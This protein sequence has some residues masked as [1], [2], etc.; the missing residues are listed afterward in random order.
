MGP[1]LRMP[2]L[3]PEYKTTV[4]FQMYFQEKNIVLY[5]G[6]Y[7]IYIY[8]Y[9]YRYI[10]TY[11]YTTTILSVFSL[12][13]CRSSRP[14]CPV[15][16]M[17]LKTGPAAS[18]TFTGAEITVSVLQSRQQRTRIQHP[19]NVLH[20]FNAA[21]EASPDA[22]TRVSSHYRKSGPFLSHDVIWCV[23][24]KRSSVF[25]SVKNLG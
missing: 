8:I 25:R 15:S 22:F 14:S 21:P 5:S 4:F 6:Q 11:Y 23:Y 24:L 2:G 1:D 16:P 3:D 18:K 12:S 13:V 17:S 7:G 19:S 9:I 10:Y 20:F